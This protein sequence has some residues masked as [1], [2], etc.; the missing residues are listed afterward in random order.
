MVGGRAWRRHKITTEVDARQTG[1]VARVADGE[2]LISLKQ[3][4]SDEENAT[5][6]VEEEV[7]APVPVAGFTM[8]VH[9]NH[10]LAELGKEKVDATSL[11]VTDVAGGQDHGRA[12]VQ[13]GHRRD[14]S[15]VVG[16]G[17]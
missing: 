7:Q 12:D 14:T 11:C 16:L 6:E 5:K 8:L 13:T 9:Y 2:S 4:S 15:C 1:R 10:I 17:R 3:K